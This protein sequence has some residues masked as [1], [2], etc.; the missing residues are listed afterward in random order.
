VNCAGIGIGRV[1][2]ELDDGT[3]EPELIGDVSCETPVTS[4]PSV[5]RPLPAGEYVLRVI[6]IQAGTEDV[7]ATVPVESAPFEI[8]AD[9]GSFVPMVFDIGGEDLLEP[10]ESPLRLSFTY[11]DT[12]DR[13]RACEPA[14]GVGGNVVLDRVTFSILE[15][16]GDEWKAVSDHAALMFDIGDLNPNVENEQITIDCPNGP[17]YSA[18]VSWG[19]YAVSAVAETGGNACFDLPATE[20]FQLA[21]GDDTNLVVLPRI[22]EGDPK[23]PPMACIECE[24]DN[25]CGGELACVAGVCD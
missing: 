25:D 9:T 15:P 2:L 6:G 4:F 22:F 1:H 18:S 17:L 3:N 10:L 21:P 14:I 16:D 5:S 7:P 24:N 8:A 20:P 23:M 13:T 19:A 12:D 11:Q